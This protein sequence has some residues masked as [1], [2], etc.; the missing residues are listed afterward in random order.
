MRP[1]RG[2]LHFEI[3]FKHHIQLPI[4]ISFAN[5]IFVSKVHKVRF[6]NDT[7]TISFRF[8]SI[9]VRIHYIFTDEKINFDLKYTN[10][11]HIYFTVLPA[12]LFHS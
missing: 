9:I 12:L 5:I 10:T 1:T 4:V 6:R 11:V 7:I 8:I 3:L 2:V